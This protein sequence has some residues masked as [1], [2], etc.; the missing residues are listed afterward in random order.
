M[1][2]VVYYL[3][4]RASF[5][6]CITTLCVGEMFG[7]L[8]YGLYVVI[9]LTYASEICPLALSV[10]LTASCNLASSLDSLL[11]RVAQLDLK[12]DWTSGLTKLHSCVYL[13]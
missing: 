6:K 11:L 13:C 4:L 1:L 8:A 10:V 2:R 12:A 3:G 9:V 7:G 5:A